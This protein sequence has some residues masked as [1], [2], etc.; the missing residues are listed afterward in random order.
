MSVGHPQPVQFG[1]T[2]VIHLRLT[3][4]ARDAKTNA[5]RYFLGALGD[6]VVIR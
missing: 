4:S 6:A 5:V 2:G 1:L 3:C